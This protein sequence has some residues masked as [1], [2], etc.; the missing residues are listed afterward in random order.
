MYRKAT[1]PEWQA[2]PSDEATTPLDYLTI[3]QIEPGISHAARHALMRPKHRRTERD[4]ASIRR[5]LL[6]L[7]GPG[8]ARAE[9][10]NA[11]ARSVVVE[12]LRR[13]FCALPGA[14]VAA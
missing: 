8:A 13:A 7:V 1:L 2:A 12:H 10:R 14:E 4:W 5:E 6:P 3:V 9:L 11:A